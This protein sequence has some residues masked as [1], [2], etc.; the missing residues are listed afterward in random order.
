M[1]ASLP[2]EQALE[3]EART[4]SPPRGRLARTFSALRYRDYRVMWIGAFLS[5]T[6]TWMAS[7]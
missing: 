2:Q 7:S 1:S 6:G 5:T 4:P 3:H